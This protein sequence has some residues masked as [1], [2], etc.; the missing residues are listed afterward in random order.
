[1]TN[2]TTRR[3]AQDDTTSEFDV[4]DGK[5]VKRENS[6]APDYEEDLSFDG[7]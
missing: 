7:L 3:D 1:M 6:D 4:E 5:L 2:G